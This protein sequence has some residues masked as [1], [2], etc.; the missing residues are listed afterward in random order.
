[1]AS[2]PPIAPAPPR[3]PA[4]PAGPPPGGRPLLWR[5]LAGAAAVVILSGTA[6]ALFALNEIHKILEAL[7]QHKPVKVARNVLTPVAKGKP[8]TL[9]LVGNDERPETRFYHQRV[10]PHSNEMLLV[11]IDPSQ[12]TI[13]ML[14]IPRE[15][16]VTFTTPDG[17]TVT[18]RLNAAYMYGYIEGGGTAGGIQLMVET[19]KHVLGIPEINHVFVT[20]FPRFENAVNEL[21]C[22]YMT[23]D[24]R[25]EHTNEPGNAEQYMEIHLQPGYQRLCGREAREFVSNRHESTSLVRDARDQRFLLEVKAQYG[26]KLFEEREKFERIFGKAVESDLQQGEQGEE[27]ILDLLELLIESSG[28]PVRQVQFPVELHPTYDTATPQQIETAVNSFLHGT[29]PIPTH[30]LNQAVRSVHVHSRGPTN[31]LTALGLSPTPTS[32]LEE[33]KQRGAALPFPIEIPLF[34]KTTAEAPPNELRTYTI[35]GPGGVRYPAYV[36]VVGSGE[37]GQFYD[38]EGTAWSNPPL[39]NAPFQALTIGHRTYDLYYD[40]EKIKTVAWR[41]DGATYWIENTLSNALSPEAMVAIARETKPLTT[42]LISSSATGNVPVPAHNVTPP[43]RPLP[44][45]PAAVKVADYLSFPLLGALLVLGGLVG[46][47]FRSL[48][49]LR[50]EVEAQTGGWR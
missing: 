34:Q 49:R 6:T 3:P 38:V 8:E 16:L 36:E 13:A 7:G 9:L 45:V 32:F 35:E 47:R 50:R 42:G 12:P 15:L 19:I 31:P 21:G 25:Y 11:R 18:T 17:E 33:A 41:E 30:S 39:F 44:T 4:P 26:P 22:V 24:K 43:P 40:G 37:L 23:V 29:A 5:L 10:L 20:N 48:A 1:V 28:K 27:E 14:S 2:A 46:L